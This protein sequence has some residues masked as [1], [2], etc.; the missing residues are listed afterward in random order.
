MKKRYSYLLWAATLFAVPAT[1]Q[2]DEVALARVIYEFTHINDT[3]QPEKPHQEEMV[4]Y[5]GQKATLY[6]TYA[7][8]RINQQIKKQLDDPSFDGNLTITGNGRTTR[9]SYY[10][11]PAE[12]VFKQL[13]NLAGTRYAIDE[14]YPTIDW[15][16][17]SDTKTIGG[18][19]VQKAT[20]SFKGRHYTVWFTT[21]VP[22]QAAPWKLLGL[23]G[24]VLEAADSRNHVVFQY[25]GFETLAAGNVTV[26]LPHNAIPTTERAFDKLRRAYEKNPQAAMNAR[27]RAGGQS[28]GG[29]PSMA[30]MDMSRIKSINVKKDGTQTSSVTNNPLELARD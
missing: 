10:A 12:H 17:T 3:L 28:A 7:T 11:K 18:Y 6:G 16:L 4:L 22:F 9:E 26:A 21:E 24:L 23:P 14:A 27:S 30:G 13:N 5:I 20:G 2:Q 19:T 25:A 1:A 15:H 29:S 8:E